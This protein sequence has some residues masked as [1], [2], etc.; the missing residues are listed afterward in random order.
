MSENH[1]APRSP[2]LMSRHD[3]ALLVVDVQT[4]LLHAMSPPP[5]LV[6][7]IGRLIDG[8]RI[9]GIPVEATEQYPKGLGATTRVLAQRLGEIPAKLM[10]S[11]RE[12]GQLFEHWRDQGIYKILVV[13]I[14]THVCVQQTVLDLLAAGFQVYVAVD[15][16]GSRYAR[17]SRDGLA[18]HGNERGDVD[19]YRSGSVRVVRGGRDTGVQASQCLGPRNAAAERFACGRGRL[20]NSP[21]LML[22]TACWHCYIALAL[23]PVAA[24]P[25]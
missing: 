22:A 20:N 21:G 15:A 5:T 1:A 8:A 3:T 12:C 16:V 9:L 24:S 7:N 13:G 19:H 6:W 14:E 25:L 2:E 10:F 17:G 4:K 11:C 23:S 18:A